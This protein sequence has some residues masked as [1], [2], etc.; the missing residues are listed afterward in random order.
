MW[1]CPRPLFLGCCS[2]AHPLCRHAGA[3]SSSV[4]QGHLMEQDQTSN[5]QHSLSPPGLS[6]ASRTAP[7]AVCWTASL[8]PPNCGA[9]HARLLPRSLLLSVSHFSPGGDGGI[10][11]DGILCGETLFPRWGMRGSGRSS[12]RPGRAG[13]GRQG[14]LPSGDAPQP[15]SVPDKGAAPAGHSGGWTAARRGRSATPR[16]P[17]ARAGGEGW[18]EGRAARPG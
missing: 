9:L 3:A 6:R 16:R 13:Q 8:F 7:T 2:T 15:R 11:T 4:L 5:N 10:P 12:A 1:K 18:G 14:T 17:E